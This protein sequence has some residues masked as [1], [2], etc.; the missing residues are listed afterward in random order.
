VSLVRLPFQI[1]E[2]LQNWVDSYFLMAKAILPHM[3]SKKRGKMIFMNLTSEYTG[4]GEGEGQLVGESSMYYSICSS[5]ITG[6]M[7]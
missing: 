5:A 3:L 1:D 4:E 6:A 2:V 7:A